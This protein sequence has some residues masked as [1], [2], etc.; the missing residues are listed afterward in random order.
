MKSTALFTVSDSIENNFIV[1]ANTVDDVAMQNPSANGD[2]PVQLTAENN[3]AADP[4]AKSTVIEST[5]VGNGIAIDEKKT[6]PGDVEFSNSQA[7]EKLALPWT[8]KYWNLFIT[9]PKSTI[10]IWGRLI[11]PEYSVGISHSFF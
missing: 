2:R 10:E 6:A 9:N 5:P 8:E 1:Y 7:L 11:G 4:V 3:V